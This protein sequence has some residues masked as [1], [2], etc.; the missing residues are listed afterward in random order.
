MLRGGGTVFGPKPRT[1]T[2]KLTKKAKKLARK[3]ALSV[4]AAEEAIT[5]VEDFTFEAPKTRQVIELLDA[6]KLTD[7]K[8][9]II[10][11]ET[12]K[13][14][15]LSARNIPGISV[16]EA[17]KPTSYQILHADVLLF[18]KSAIP[19][20]ENTFEPKVEEEAA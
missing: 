18:L 16:I 5:V 13:N 12:D 1:Y 15:F 19:V 6:L 14:I 10:T 7:K 3:S 2:I 8:V 9:L 4:K 20:L 11:A 17:D